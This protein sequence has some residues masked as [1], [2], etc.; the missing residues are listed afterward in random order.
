[1]RLYSEEEKGCESKRDV[2]SKEK[3]DREETERIEALMELNIYFETSASGNFNVNLERL[4]G[5]V[6]K[7]GRKIK[8]GETIIKVGEA[9]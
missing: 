6:R 9:D 3:T 5:I 2:K 4:K 1:M 8:G 7:T